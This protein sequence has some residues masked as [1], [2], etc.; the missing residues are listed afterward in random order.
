MVKGAITIV[1]LGFGFLIGVYYLGGYASWDPAEKC[2]EAKNAIQVGMTWEEVVDAIGEP[3]KYQLI[4]EEEELQF[5]EKVTIYHP[6]L[7]RTFE[8]GL[9]EADVANDKVPYGFLFIYRY[10]QQ[11]AFRLW[12][13]SDSRVEQL[14]EDRT[15]DMLLQRERD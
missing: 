15:M 7:I 13:D 1:V 8:R 10:S 11:E 6:G 14:E 2:R 9:V 3:G 5:G 12:F 4:I